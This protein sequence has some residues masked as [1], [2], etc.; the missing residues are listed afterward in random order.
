MHTLP[1]P[2]SVH[3]SRQW[4]W[5]ILVYSLWVCCC[6]DRKMLC[7]MWNSQN[8]SLEGCWR[9]Y[10]LMQRLWNTVSESTLKLCAREGNLPVRIM[11]DCSQIKLFSG[12]YMSIKFKLGDLHCDAL[13]Y[14]VFLNSHFMMCDMRQRKKTKSEWPLNCGKKE[15]VKMRLNLPRLELVNN[16]G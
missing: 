5:I 7:I 12:F 15:L 8:S 11:T 3:N 4:Q 6:H 14:Y 16:H 2:L 10:F 9:W 13:W 1:F